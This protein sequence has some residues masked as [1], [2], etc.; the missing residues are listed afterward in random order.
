MLKQQQL[1]IDQL[2]TQLKNLQDLVSSLLSENRSFKESFNRELSDRPPPFMNK[3]NKYKPALDPRT[4]YCT[5]CGRHYH[6]SRTCYRRQGKCFRCGSFFH[7]VSFCYQPAKFNKGQQKSYQRSPQKKPMPHHHVTPM[8]TAPEKN[9]PVQSPS[10]VP[11]TNVNNASRSFKSL[12]AEPCLSAQ[13]EEPSETV[14]PSSLSETPIVNLSAPIETYNNVIPKSAPM[15]S[16][17]FLWLDPLS[18]D[19]V[20]VKNESPVELIKNIST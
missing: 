1:M 11:V 8:S 14:Q 17:I 20:H 16:P 19:P 10:S 6:T 13:V 12:P 9:H 7:T 3:R 2:T 18:P 5:W 15:T 4:L